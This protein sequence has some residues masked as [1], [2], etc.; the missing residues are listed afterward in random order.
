MRL[1][2][3]AADLGGSRKKRQMVFHDADWRVLNELLSGEPYFF[4][5][6][7]LFFFFFFAMHH[8]SWDPC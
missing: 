1:G 7:F 2:S 4:P 6:V 5:P 8:G 3:C